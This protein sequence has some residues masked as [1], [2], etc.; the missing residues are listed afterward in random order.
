MPTR[1]KRPTVLVPEAAWSELMKL[2]KTA[3]ADM[4]WSYAQR[5][6]GSESMLD[7]LDDFRR[8]WSSVR[9]ARK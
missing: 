9:E 2:S 5:C 6:A 1:I 4:V 8:E 7:A 3:L